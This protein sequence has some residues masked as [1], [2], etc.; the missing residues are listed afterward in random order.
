MRS[1][2]GV[3]ARGGRRETHV[4]LCTAGD[5]E[6]G[7][8]GRRRRGSTALST[9]SN[10]ALEVPSSPT[11]TVAGAGATPRN[12]TDFLL[13]ACGRP[14]RPLVVGRHTRSAP[15][16]AP[17]PDCA[18][19]EPLAHVAGSTSGRHAPSTSIARVWPWATAGPGR[20]VLGVVDRAQRDTRFIGVLA[21][22]VG[23]RRHDRARVRRL[24]WRRHVGGWLAAGG[25]AT[26]NVAPGLAPA[27][28]ATSSRHRSAP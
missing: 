15:W 14:G 23:W 27:G 8:H 6:H 5:R 26:S 10:G 9:E 11:H 3:R 22:A 4:W 17:G 18:E 28:I 19:P 21:R 13:V 2:G 7:A 12:Q 20:A 24:R 16:P 1:G 25:I